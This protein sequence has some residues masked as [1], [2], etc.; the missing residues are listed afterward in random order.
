MRLIVAIAPSIA[1]YDAN[2]SLRVP[3]VDG[4][5]DITVCRF[6]LRP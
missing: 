2:A 5:I 3:L 1:G 4:V 6:E